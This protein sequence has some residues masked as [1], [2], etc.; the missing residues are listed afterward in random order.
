MRDHSTNTMMHTCILYVHLRISMYLYMYANCILSGQFQALQAFDT[1]ADP[2]LAAA[3]AESLRTA[4]GQG[5]SEAAAAT[6]CVAEEVEDQVGKM[7][8]KRLARFG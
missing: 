3:I 5:G 2:E 8:R 7:R 6:T 1:N 4:G